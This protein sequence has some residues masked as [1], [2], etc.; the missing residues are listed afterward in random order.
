MQLL[1]R[2]HGRPIPRK[3][4]RE[5]KGRVENSPHKSQ[6]N[7]DDRRLEFLNHLPY[8]ILTLTQFLLKPPQ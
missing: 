7:A 4:S 5:S 2:R 1:N 6:W 8:F 3:N